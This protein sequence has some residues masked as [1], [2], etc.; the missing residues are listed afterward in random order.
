MKVCL[1]GKRV[2]DFTAEDGRRVCGFTLYIGHESDDT[3][4]DGFI[5]EK[6]FVS[7]EKVAVKDLTVGSDINVE[8]NNRG[9]VIA[10]SAI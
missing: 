4:V 9:R 5:V 3:T 6:V 7:S 1:L 10:V 8:F 2:V